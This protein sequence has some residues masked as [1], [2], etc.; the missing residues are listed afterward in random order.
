MFL[1]ESQCS[2]SSLSGCFLQ[3]HIRL[4]IGQFMG[5]TSK[6]FPFRRTWWLAKGVACDSWGAQFGCQPGGFL[7][8]DGAAG[9]SK[10]ITWRSGDTELWSLILWWC[11]FSKQPNIHFF[12]ARYQRAPPSPGT[13]CNWHNVMPFHGDLTAE[14]PGILLWSSFHLQTDDNW[15]VVTGGHEF[16]CFP[17][18]DQSSQLSFDYHPIIGENFPEILGFDDHPVIDDLSTIFQRGD[19]KKHTR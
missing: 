11:T 8:V 6:Q 17:I 5:A 7:V 3:H 12:I 13:S 16:W 14:S 9:D 19:Q 10:V 2:S 15:L 18:D 4:V 1:V